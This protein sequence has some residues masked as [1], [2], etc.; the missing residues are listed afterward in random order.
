MSAAF[1][2]FWAAYPRREG[3]AACEKK[4]E[5]KR[6]DAQA[7]VIVAHVEKRARED[8]KWKDGYIPMPLTFLNQERWTDE[9]E[10]IRASRPPSPTSASPEPVRT[11]PQPC[12]HKSSLNLS[13]LAVVMSDPYAVT[14]DGLRECLRQR[15][16]WADEL[17]AMYGNGEVPAED[18]RQL[19][20]NYRKRYAEVIRGHI[21]GERFDTTGIGPGG[22]RPAAVR[23]SEAA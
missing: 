18:W 1:D 23:D 12:P 17:R 8:K 19:A 20:A 4:W 3:R 10:V 6:L 22:N 11:W 14:K 2:R 15:N 21:G 5:Q 16:R 7:D 13:L 9:Y